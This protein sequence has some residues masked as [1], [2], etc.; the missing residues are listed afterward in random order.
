MPSSTTKDIQNQ[1]KTKT[2][3]PHHNDND[4]SDI[5]NTGTGN[6]NGNLNNNNNNSH[7]DDT[8]G[9]GRSSLQPNNI[10]P[11]DP[12]SVDECLNLFK[13]CCKKKADFGLEDMFWI[14]FLL[15]IILFS[16][17]KGFT[18]Y[19]WSQITYMMLGSLGILILL[20]IGATIFNKFVLEDS[21]T[22]HWNAHARYTQAAIHC[23]LNEEEQRVHVIAPPKMGGAK[24]NIIYSVGDVPLAK[25]TSSGSSSTINGGN[26][27]SRQGSISSQIG[28][29]PNALSNI[30]AQAIQTAAALLGQPSSNQSSI[31]PI[32]STTS[33]SSSTTSMTTTTTI[34][35]TI[36]KPSITSTHYTHHQF[37]HQTIPAIKSPIIVNKTSQTSDSSLTN[38]MTT[39]TTVSMATCSLLP[40]SLKDEII[41]EEDDRPET[42]SFHSTNGNNNNNNDNNNQEHSSG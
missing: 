34:T 29:M 7:N 10:E 22:A 38:Q 23:R 37:H 6:K 17:L 41:A 15:I 36:T 20:Y 16:I 33:S 18:R 1:L 21:S 31:N 2:I 3:D 26:P 27:H 13:A 12:S 32:V 19:T 25:T 11:G 8:T 40:S 30:T 5:A 24:L 9:G 4:H 35:S 42:P 14:M 28:I 39:G